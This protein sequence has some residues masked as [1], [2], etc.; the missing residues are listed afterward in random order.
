MK[1]GHFRLADDWLKTAILINMSVN[2]FCLFFMEFISLNVE[3]AVFKELP[4]CAPRPPP[5]TAPV[6]IPSSPVGGPWS[7]S[8]GSVF[9]IISGLFANCYS[10]WHEVMHHCS[11]VLHFLLFSAG[12]HLS[13]ASCPSKRAR[14]P[15][16]AQQLRHTG[17]VAPEHVEY[18]WTRD[19]ARV[20]C[21]VRWIL[22]HWV[23]RLFSFISFWDACIFCIGI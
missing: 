17:L 13:F 18:S 14:C 3:V 20:P 4:L 8:L 12:E 2:L 6:Y 22:H 23:T 19:Q 11:F 1:T 21:T 16:Q 5:M 9:D 10:D 7:P 15:T